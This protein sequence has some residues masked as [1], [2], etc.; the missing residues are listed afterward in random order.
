MSWT[1][2]ADLRNQVDRLWRRGI[3][4]EELLRISTPVVEDAADSAADRDS[5]TSESSSYM[6]RF[7]MRLTLKRPN[8]TQLVERFDEVR[9]WIAELNTGQFYRVESREVR[10]RI[11]GA[12]R[13]PH[14]VWVDTLEDALAMIGKSRDAERFH[15]LASMTRV[16]RPELLLW[17]ERYPLKALEFA[18]VWPLLLDVVAWIRERPRPGVY[19]RQIDLPGIHTKFIEEHRVV[20][21]QLLD[22]VLP[23]DAID[24]TATG[25]GGFAR[26]YGFRDKPLRVRFRILDPRLSLSLDNSRGLSA[27]ARSTSSGSEIGPYSDQDFEMTARDFARLQVGAARVFITENEINFLSFPPVSGALIIFGGGYGF[28]M[29]AEAEWLNE[30]E[31]HYWGDIDTHG[32]AI[33]DQLRAHLPNAKSF[34][35]DRKTLMVHERLWGEEPDQVRR[36]LGRLDPDERQLYDDLCAGRIEMSARVR[37]DAGIRL[38]QERISF[39]WMEDALMKLLSGEGT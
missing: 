9:D 21:A 30:C 6:G 10:H 22:L 23:P 16:R 20:L 24:P 35:M 7:P 37:G 39:G 33:L 14:R 13:V 34:L 26:R 25:V 15:D 2:P 32:F 36:D 11:L 18:D 8:S 3:L 5:E 38:E 28:E 4:L 27:G 29:L 31:I 17:L 12:N 1:R 19:L